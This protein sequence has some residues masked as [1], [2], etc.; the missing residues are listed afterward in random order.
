MWSAWVFKRGVEQELQQGIQQGIR[1][2][3]LAGIELGL[4]LKFNGEGLRLL[5][6]IYK[7]EDVDVLR[8]IHEGI[9]TVD[10]LEELRR[11]YT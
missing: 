1:Q 8:A 9:E 7:I 2:G 5:P 3:L 11:I 4:K 6:E 10:T